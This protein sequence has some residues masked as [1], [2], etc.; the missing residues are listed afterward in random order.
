LKGFGED[1]PNDKNIFG[2]KFICFPNGRFLQTCLTRVFA[3]FCQERPY[4][5]WRGVARC[6]ALLELLEIVSPLSNENKARHCVYIHL[7]SGV[8][9]VR[10]MTKGDLKTS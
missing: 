8:E 10:R 4:H 1:Q 7:G 9:L 6:D 2:G 5:G 3:I